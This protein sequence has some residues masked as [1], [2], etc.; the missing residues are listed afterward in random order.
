VREGN[1]DYWLRRAQVVVTVNSTVGFR[2]VELHRPVIVL[3]RALY[4]LEGIAVA[5][6]PSDLSDHLLRCIAGEPLVD[7]QKISEFIGFLRHRYQ[8]SGNLRDYDDH[9][10][11]AVAD[12][13]LELRNRQAVGS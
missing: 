4:A 11:D 8:V 12:R 5:A 2:A 9:V 13:I 1:T 7:E 10:L 6:T 3:G